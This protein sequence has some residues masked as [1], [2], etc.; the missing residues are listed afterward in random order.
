VEI[1]LTVLALRLIED[2][3]DRQRM[4]ARIPAART[5][6]NAMAYSTSRIERS[7][8]SDS[9]A[10]IAVCRIIDRDSCLLASERIAPDGRAGSVADDVTGMGRR[11]R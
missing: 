9:A 11:R 1:D 8:T 5:A 6:T 3:A 10:G 7:S 2:R 4:K